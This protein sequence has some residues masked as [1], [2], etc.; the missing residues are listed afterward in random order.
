MQLCYVTYSSQ[1][2]CKKVLD[3][4]STIIG[5]IHHELRHERIENLN[6]ITVLHSALREWRQSVLA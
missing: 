3:R 1:L 6:W 2:A 5:W 4:E